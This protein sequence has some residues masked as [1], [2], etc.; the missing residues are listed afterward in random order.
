LPC[1]FPQR[2]PDH[3]VRPNLVPRSASCASFNQSSARRTQASLS[4]GLV[5]FSA[6]SRH[7]SASLRNLSASVWD[8][9]V[10]GSSSPTSSTWEWSCLWDSNELSRETRRAIG[11][12][13][14]DTRNYYC[15]GSANALCAKF[16]RAAPRVY[17]A[18]SMFS[19]VSRSSCLTSAFDA[20]LQR[21]WLEPG[22]SR[23]YLPSGSRSTRP[24]FAAACAHR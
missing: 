8:D 20:P 22:R 7:S 9:G 5:A 13:K 4:R 2:K 1:K 14:E 24:A 19:R 3:P 11:R 10:I 18:E 16:D 17:F 6:R 15:C 21:P 12:S 23:V